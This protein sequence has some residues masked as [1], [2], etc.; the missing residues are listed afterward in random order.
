VALPRAVIESVASTYPGWTF[1]KDTYLV[2]YYDNDLAGK[3]TKRYKIVLKKDNERI[4][5]KCDEEG[6]F[7]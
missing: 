5:V 4:R 7:L 6:N 1:A 3:I 2:N